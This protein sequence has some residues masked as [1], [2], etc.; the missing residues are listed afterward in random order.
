[1]NGDG[2]DEIINVVQTAFFIF[3]GEGAQLGS[4][5]LGRNS[6]K[7]IGIG[8]VNGDGLDEIIH[9]QRS[10]GV[11]NVRIV[12]QNGTLLR[13]FPGVGSET[14][15]VE[16]L[17]MAK[18]ATDQDGDGLFDQWGIHGVD[19]DL[20]GTID[21][22]LLR[23]C[24][25]PVHKDL[26]LELDWVAG[27][28]P[29]KAAIAALKEAFAAAPISAGGTL[30]PDGQPGIRLL[31]DTGG[32]TDPNGREDGHAAGSCSDGEIMVEMVLPMLMILTV[33]LGTT[34]VAGTQ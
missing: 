12:N 33:W 15:P 2:K 3:N 17:F 23:F 31:V 21:I 22:D 19:T 18:T 14:Q 27:Q 25:S 10:L 34:S 29:T 1:M 5:V 4:F 28:E 11:L 9:G 8:D 7:P 16:I 26:F 20:D 24:P 6:D 30:N 13:E 32:L